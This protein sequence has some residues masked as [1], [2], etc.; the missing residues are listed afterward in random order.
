MTDKPRPY[1]PE[2]EARFR[3]IARPDHPDGDL[4]LWIDR[5]HSDPTPAWWWGASDALEAGAR[6]PA[7][8][9]DDVK[10]EAEAGACE[11]RPTQLR[12]QE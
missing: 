1:R 11:A 12:G 7:D 8:H 9:K 5:W 10:P 6:E 3:R 4:Y 2:E